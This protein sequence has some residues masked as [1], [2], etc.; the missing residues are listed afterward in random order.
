MASVGC[1]LWQN[2]CTTT[3]LCGKRPHAVMTILLSYGMHTYM[4]ART[5][6]VN[7]L[8]YSVLLCMLVS[9]LH[10]HSMRTTLQRRNPRA[11]PDPAVIS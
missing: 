4:I 8:P 11:V 1:W 7:M 10:L 6:A 2:M 3:S 9:K 5:L